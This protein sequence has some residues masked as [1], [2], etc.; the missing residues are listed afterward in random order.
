M[1]R[2][3]H[4]F[5]GA[6]RAASLPLLL[7]GIAG[8]V[9]IP[10]HAAGPGAP[11]AIESLVSAVGR[12][13]ADGMTNVEVRLLNDADEPVAFAP[14]RRIEARLLI[15]G[16]NLP[17]WLE[18]P[19]GTPD[20]LT[21]AAGGFARVTYRFHAP[22]PPAP[23]TRAILSVPDWHMQPVAF[24]LDAREPARDGEA[25]LAAADTA[26]KGSDGAAPVD[27]P[28]PAPGDRS[29]GNAFLA[30]LSAY[31]PI[32][33]V[34]G[35]DTATDARIQVSFK[36]QLFGS[37]S[38]R[39]LPQSWRDGLYFGYTQRMFWA[40]GT[41]SSPFRNVDYQPELFYLTPAMTLSGSTKLNVQLGLRHESNGRDG[42]ASR[43]FNTVY[44]S[45]MAALPLGHG[46][47]LEVA[48]RLAFFVGGLDDN[49]DIRRYRGNGGLSLQ[50]GR[51][52]GLRLATF[53]RYDPGSG[54]G[55]VSADLSY[56][57]PRLL[58]G[59]PDFYLYAQ[60]FA[61]YGENLLDYD[62]RVTRLRIG[63]AL[64]R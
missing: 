39:G 4:R 25:R 59:G 3:H 40:L 27:P 9:A 2:A 53:A 48:P 12:P 11:P 37:R 7:T 32:Y 6:R 10:A 19:S 47:R 42:A 8:A 23:G 17:V 62:R 34:Y 41:A 50:V 30:N 14:P 63:V 36:Y 31:Q 5:P 44:V 54:K 22:A 28:L 49:P 46:Y 56:P 33:A 64:V 52:D 57:L 61:G 16:D 60:S 45:P 43:S 38:R 15:G 1:P 58:G 51:D 24:T 13:G 18:R 20:M 26:P 35:P 55:A 21:I 29:A